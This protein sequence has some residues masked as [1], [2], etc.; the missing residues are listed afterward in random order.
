MEGSEGLGLGAPC[1]TFGAMMSVSLFLGMPMT[2][3]PLESGVDV[4]QYKQGE[5]EPEVF[6]SR[7]DGEMGGLT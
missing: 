5:C 7:C 6:F 1:A 3:H 2:W 4:S